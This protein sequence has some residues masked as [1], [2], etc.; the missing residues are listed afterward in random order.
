[1][2]PF[3]PAQH[4]L[5]PKAWSPRRRLNGVPSPRPTE[6]LVDGLD[7]GCRVHG[8]QRA[9]P[10]VLNGVTESTADEEPGADVLG[11]GAES[12]AD[13]KPGAGLWWW[14]VPNPLPTG[15]LLRVHRG[16]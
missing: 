7:G 12:T 15:K 3:H 1:M 5:R 6:S 2:R 13:G 9:W 16:A 11:R 10:D 4:T 14:G 8:R